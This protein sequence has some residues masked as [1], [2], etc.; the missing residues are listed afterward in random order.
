LDTTL[1]PEAPDTAAPA[2]T[3]PTDA[4]ATPRFAD[5]PL[6]QAGASAVD[7]LA[8]EL[9]GGPVEKTVTFGPNVYTQESFDDP[10]LS[11]DLGPARC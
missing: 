6:R 9:S 3:A 1:L 2:D 5:F 11:K 8:N 7:Q 10:E 4:A